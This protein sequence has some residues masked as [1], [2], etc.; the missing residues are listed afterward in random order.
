MVDGD[1]ERG[2]A[3]RDLAGVKSLRGLPRSATTAMMGRS[4]ESCAKQRRLI[5][6]YHSPPCALVAIALSNI[7]VASFTTF[8]LKAQV[9]EIQL[10]Q[11]SFFLTVNASTPHPLRVP[12]RSSVAVPS[13][14]ELAGQTGARAAVGSPSPPSSVHYQSFVLIFDAFSVLPADTAFS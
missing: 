10:Q 11:P 13:F 12:P 2:E 3:G 14:K 6:K 9:M 8:A 5:L 1:E 4:S 7:T